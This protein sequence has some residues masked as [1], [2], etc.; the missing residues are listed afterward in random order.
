MKKSIAT[1]LAVTLLLC[2]AMAPM[3]YGE[4][5]TIVLTIGDPYMSVNGAKQ[6]ID[7]GRGTKP[8]TVEGRTLVPIRTVIENMGGTIA[9]DGEKSQVTISANN[10]TIR[11]TIDYNMAEI[12]DQSS[13]SDWVKKS[14]DV[15][16]KVIN[17]RTMV[18][19]RF[20][21]ENLGCS[22]AW[23]E[24][25]QSVTITMGVAKFDPLNWTGSWE[26]NEGI[27]TLNQTGDLVTGSNQYW[28][29]IEGKVSGKT[30]T[31]KWFKAV[32][33]Q[34]DIEMTL[35]DDGK[36]YT[37][38]WRYNQPDN[39]PDPQDETGGW[40]TGDVGQRSVK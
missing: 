24:A 6:E 39:K 33:S 28:G 23:D 22:V 27:L 26:S 35:S 16:P 12:K 30:L 19:L 11:V 4:S 37:T 3:A 8:V 1:I 20:A 38:K 40:Q 18:P 15:P 29:K 7:P 13:A 17:D 31:G 21:T 5:K 9:W 25:T 32:T 36:S 14:M 34:G 10:K 2:L